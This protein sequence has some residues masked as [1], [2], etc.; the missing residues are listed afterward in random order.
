MKSQIPIPNISS[1]SFPKE[2]DEIFSH[3]AGMTREEQISL[4]NILT[5]SKMNLNGLQTNQNSN[6]NPSKNMEINNNSNLKQETSYPQERVSSFKIA[7]EEMVKNQMSDEESIILTNM[8]RHL[9]NEMKDIKKIVNDFQVTMNEKD[10]EIIKLNLELDDEKN[11]FHN[12]RMNSDSEFSNISP[13]PSNRFER[14]DKL[15]KQMNKNKEI[16]ERQNSDIGNNIFLKTENYKEKEDIYGPKYEEHDSKSKS[17]IQTLRVN[18]DLE[19]IIKK[20][21]EEISSLKNSLEK[22]KINNGKIIE[23]YNQ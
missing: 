2:N 7:K 19:T 20:Q 10:A 16:I 18:M 8:V 1:P 22:E 4:L 5:E 13:V 11:K 14:T 15:Y 12:R 23:Q 21:R 6:I 3:V 9:D 17:E